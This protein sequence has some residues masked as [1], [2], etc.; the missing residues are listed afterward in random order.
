[1]FELHFGDIS[2]SKIRSDRKR[3]LQVLFEIIGNAI[4][5]TNSG[6]ISIKVKGHEPGLLWI[7]V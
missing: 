7:K 4:K 2:E 3:V 6:K 5:Y 1:L